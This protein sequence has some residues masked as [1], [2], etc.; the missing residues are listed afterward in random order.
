MQEEIGQILRLQGSL[1]K[2]LKVFAEKEVAKEGL[3][4]K[5]LPFEEYLKLIR[6]DWDSIAQNK[7]L[8]TSEKNRIIDVFKEALIVRNRYAHPDLKEKEVLDFVKDCHTLYRL[9]EIIGASPED[10]EQIDKYQNT[11]LSKLSIRNVNLKNE[12]DPKSRV[13]DSEQRKKKKSRVKEFT[14][15]KSRLEVRFYDDS[16]CEKEVLSVAAGKTLHV[17]NKTKVHSCPNKCREKET[18][19]EYKRKYTYRTT[20]YIAFRNIKG[21]MGTLYGVKKI[22]VTD[23]KKRDDLE[24]LIDLALKQNVLD[25]KEVKR[26]KA[27]CKDNPFSSN[28]RIYILGENDSVELPHLPAPEGDSLLP[29]YFS[30]SEMLSGRKVILPDLSIVS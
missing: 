1:L 7:N 9:A 17:I 6:N 23:L 26:L 18:T 13:P 12:S 29:F 27:Y 28:E 24:G 22:L 25:G 8:G 19:E 21:E 16:D 3:S 15:K 11:L 5:S 10:I 4:A 20:R 30:L 14:I 2:H